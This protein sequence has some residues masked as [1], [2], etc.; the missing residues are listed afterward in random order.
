MVLEWFTEA[1]EVINLICN[2]TWCK[3]YKMSCIFRG[4]IILS[5]Y[6]HS[7]LAWCLEG[8]GSVMTQKMCSI[9]CFDSGCH[10]ASHKN[11]SFKTTSWGEKKKVK[12]QECLCLALDLRC[13]ELSIP[14]HHIHVFLRSFFKGGLYKT[15]FSSM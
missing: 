7:Y 2:I 9:Y 5:E 13:V 6:R 15:K 12:Y 4:S 3:S 11:G 10:E 1:Q 8:D 14:V